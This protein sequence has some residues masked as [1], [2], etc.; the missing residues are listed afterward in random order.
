MRAQNASTIA[1]STGAPTAPRMVL[2]EEQVR[3]VTVRQA[4]SEG[5]ERVMWSATLK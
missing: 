3:A 4:R 2:L 5:L 1:L